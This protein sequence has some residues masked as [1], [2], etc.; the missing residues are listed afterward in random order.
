MIERVLIVDD[1][2]GLR[3]ALERYLVRCGYEV[4]QAGTAH[5]ALLVVQRQKISCVVLDIGLPDESGID[6]VP[7]LLAVE[8]M[9]AIVMLT[10]VAEVS[11][12]ILCMQRGAFDYLTKP[13]ELAELGGVI[14]RAMGRREQRLVQ[15]RSVGS[16]K[17]EVARLT[18]EVHRQQARFENHSVATLESLVYLMEAK[19]TYL[20]GHSVRVA[21]VS[22]SLAAQLGR[23]DEEVEVVRLAAQLHDIGMICIDDHV[24]SK[25]SRLTDE[26]MGQIRR[27]TI[28]G[29]QIL[30]PIPNLAVVRGFVRGHHERWDGN[31]Y[32]DGLAGHAIPWGARVIGTVEV[33]D[34]LT[35]T[36]PYQEHLRP[37][38]AIERMR[39][40]VGTL[41]GPE[42][43]EAMAIVADRRQALVFLE[44]ATERAYGSGFPPE[45]LDGAALPGGPVAQPIVEATQPGGRPRTRRDATSG[46]NP[47][48]SPAPPL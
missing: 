17:D 43:F 38:Q 5:E 19:S 26:E 9:L 36:R 48:S 28:V 27:H 10:A 37:D 6:L 47:A 23:S 8:P 34:A 12:A 4:V 32:P 40:L 30:G 3:S 31:G 44:D 42:E 22:A 2:A 41:L 46:G 7:R 35:T 33:F 21:Q 25:Q 16:L 15:H 14:Q 1:E 24:L 39:Q 13:T 45:T 29:A 11:T 20:A 18:V